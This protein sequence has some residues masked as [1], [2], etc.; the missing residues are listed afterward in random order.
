MPTKIITLRLVA[1][2]E[3]LSRAET[4]AW[5]RAKVL[6]RAC[7]STQE[8]CAIDFGM[9]PVTVHKYEARKMKIPARYLVALEDKARE[10]GF[11]IAE[12]P[13]RAA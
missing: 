3:R 4:R 1:T 8:E 5:L 9:S 6:R 10:L 12:Q 11:V 13:R 2:S 7:Y